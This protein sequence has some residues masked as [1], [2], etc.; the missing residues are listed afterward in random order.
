MALDF[1]KRFFGPRDPTAFGL[2]WSPRLTLGYPFILLAACGFVAVAFSAGLGLPRI[3]LFVPYA[4]SVAL[5][6]FGLLLGMIDPRDVCKWQ[7]EEFWE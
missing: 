1:L 4:A 6:G 5:F 2:N 3:V 7:L